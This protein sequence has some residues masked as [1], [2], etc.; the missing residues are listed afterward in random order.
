MNL[1]LLQFCF[2]I[3]VLSAHILEAHVEQGNLTTEQLAR[4]WRYSL[5]VISSARSA[6]KLVHDAGRGEGKEPFR[7]F[8]TSIDNIHRLALKERPNLAA[9]LPATA[10]LLRYT[11]ETRRPAL[12]TVAEV[13]AFL[14]I[15]PRTLHDHARTGS[16]L[17]FQP[18]GSGKWLFPAVTVEKYKSAHRVIPPSVPR[19]GIVQAHVAHITG[20]TVET[21]SLYCRGA[22]PKFEIT[23]DARYPRQLVITDR[24]LLAYL[25]HYLAKGAD[26][27]LNF[28]ALDWIMLRFMHNDPLITLHKAARHCSVPKS[29]V[30]AAIT[31]GALPCLWTAGGSTRIPTH[32]V[33]MW[34]ST[35]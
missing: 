7:Y 8:Y 18:L 16:I 15:S 1:Q 24:S 26:G 6:G 28:T 34:A 35:V 32:A 31:S 30:T 12:M 11:E 27:T 2:Y 13:C 25:D 20:L 5:N 14:E 29:T 9:M 23:K 17:G 21:I 19:R 3:L 4:F 33:E 10:E 22:T